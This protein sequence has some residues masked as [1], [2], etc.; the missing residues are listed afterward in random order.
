MTKATQKSHTNFSKNIP[1]LFL[2]FSFFFCDNFVTQFIERA[3]NGVIKKHSMIW[4]TQNKFK[5]CYDEFHMD[6]YY[7]Y[8]RFYTN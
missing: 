8:K 3:F 1:W 7:H 6:L 4:F 5:G 2:F